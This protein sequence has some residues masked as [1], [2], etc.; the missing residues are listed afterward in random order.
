MAIMLRT[1]E[2]KKKEK[3]VKNP[4]KYC[5]AVRMEFVNDNA[6]LSTLGTDYASHETSYI[7][8]ADNS[9]LGLD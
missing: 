7:I 8:L 5:F 2:L 9:I 6:S 4:G 3:N 1:E